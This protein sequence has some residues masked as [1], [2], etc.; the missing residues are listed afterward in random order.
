MVLSKEWCQSSLC[1]NCPLLAWFLIE[2]KQLAIDNHLCLDFFSKEVHNVC[3]AKS[4]GYPLAINTEVI[5]T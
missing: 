4:P 2:F 3:V 5:I 1:L